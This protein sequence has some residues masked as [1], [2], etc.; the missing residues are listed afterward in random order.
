M[1]LKK[2]QL[3]RTKDLKKIESNWLT[4]KTCDPGHET[5]ITPYKARKKIQIKF[6]IN[7]ILKDEV[8][9]F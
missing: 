7:S 1:K 2:N 8:E 9:F 5:I 3:K 6:S 4:R